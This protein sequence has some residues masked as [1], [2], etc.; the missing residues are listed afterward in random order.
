MN[1]NFEYIE[2]RYFFA[3]NNIFSELNRTK[4]AVF[5]RGTLGVQE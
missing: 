3:E 5:R 1:R 2:Q 4:S